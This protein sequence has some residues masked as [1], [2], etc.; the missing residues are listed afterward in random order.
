METLFVSENHHD[1]IDD[2]TEVVIYRSYYVS[3][4]ILE[5]LFINENIPKGGFRALYIRMTAVNIHVLYYIKKS[6]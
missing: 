5:A 3:L 1:D 4:F 2:C 6:G